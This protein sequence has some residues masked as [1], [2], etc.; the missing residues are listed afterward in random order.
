[1]T[2]IDLQPTLEGDL[3]EL[4][5]LHEDDFNNLYAVA[6]DAELWAQ[7]PA[8]DRWQ[9]EVFEQFF[10]EAL[11]RRGALVII[12]KATGRMIGSSRYHAYSSE[13]DEVEIGW[14]FLARS[15]W[16][17]TV[18]RE[19][20]RLM[21]QHAFGFVSNII[22]RVGVTNWRSQRAMEKIGGVKIGVRPDAAGNE[23]Y[24]YRITKSDFESGAFSGAFE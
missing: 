15:H 2:A 17:G 4:R 18:N 13:L 9:P 5:P 22:F 23:S 7:H 12:D 1:M 3:L 21:L 19:L 14:T 24:I 11:E 6:S 20:K 8:N 10:D 16:G